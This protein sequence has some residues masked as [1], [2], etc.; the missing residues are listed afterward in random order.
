LNVKDS[1][2]LRVFSLISLSKNYFWNLLVEMT[3]PV[4]VKSK[5]IVFFQVLQIMIV[6]SD[7]VM[8]DQELV[9]LCQCYLWFMFSLIFILRN[10][11]LTKVFYISIKLHNTSICANDLHKRQEV[12]DLNNIFIRILLVLKANFNLLNLFES[13]FDFFY[14]SALFLH[15]VCIFF[16]G[17]DYLVLG[18]V[19]FID[20]SKCKWIHGICT[21][22]LY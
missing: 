3:A 16:S 22:K 7:F 5:Q 20:I 9:I 17:L 8:K 14:S 12:K 19:T 13:S 21:P 11:R 6:F 1:I 4:F 18:I 10:L 2:A 15:A